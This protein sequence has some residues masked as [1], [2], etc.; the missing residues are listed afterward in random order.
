MAIR[1][2]VNELIIPVFRTEGYCYNISE[3]NVLGVRTDTWEDIESTWDYSEYSD[4][5]TCID[6]VYVCADP[7]VSG[8]IDPF[9]I[10]ASYVTYSSRPLSIALDTSASSNALMVISPT[11]ATASV[12]GITV[13][14][15][16]VIVLS[17]SLVDCSSFTLS[18][19]GNTVVLDG[20]LT[21]TQVISALVNANIPYLTPNGTVTSFDL[22]NASFA[23]NPLV[24]HVTAATFNSSGSVSIVPTCDF[25][26]ELTYLKWTA[27]YDCITGLWSLTS[28]ASSGPSY[29]SWIEGSSGYE[30]V[31]KREN[32]SPDISVLPIPACYF[33]WSATYDCL[34]SSW[35]IS[36]DFVDNTGPVQDWIDYG[37]YYVCVTD[38]PVTPDPPVSPPTCYYYWSSTY[39]CGTLTWSTPN[40]DFVDSFG[41]ETPWTVFDY[42]ASC[43]T[44]TSTV[45]DLPTEVPVC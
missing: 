24:F 43:V 31:I 3:H 34:S 1:L 5:S 8:T 36:L 4:C 22:K 20:T 18:V 21:Q 27:V 29:T 28:T 11:V 45:P 15:G 10:F 30:T 39:N 6:S 44:T 32:L 9:S 13:S 26:P 40:L 17:D 2:P 37:G 35:V 23:Y 14:D 12:S 41:F 38:T 7:I 33:W 16:F 42:D 25:T 19:G